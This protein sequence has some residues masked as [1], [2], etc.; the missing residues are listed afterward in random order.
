MLAVVALSYEEE[1][2]ITM[3]ERKK[4]LL[5]LKDDPVA[6]SFTQVKTNN[7]ETS[8]NRANKQKFCSQK[9]KK[10]TLSNI[11]QTSVLLPAQSSEMIKSEGLKNHKEVIN[12]Q[13]NESK[14]KF[15]SNPI[16][17][18]VQR[19]SSLDDSGVVDDHDDQ[20]TFQIIEPNQETSINNTDIASIKLTV[21]KAYKLK[22][23]EKHNNKLN[24]CINPVLHSNYTS[25]IVVFGE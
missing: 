5:E 14:S 13:F 7:L 10:K 1:A 20:D 2:E 19:Q 11:P 25:Q 23:S 24:K 16:E 12:M 22:N 21:S 9:K 17:C 4:D 3:E 6:K 8:L 18:V 15:C